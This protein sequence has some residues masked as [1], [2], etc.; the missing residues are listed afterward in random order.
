MKK[1]RA[2]LWMLLV[3][4]LWAL[5]AQKTVVEVGVEGMA[6]SACSYRVEKELGKLDGVNGVHVSLK[7]KKARIVF[8]PGAKPDLEKI[9]KTITDAGF[10]PGKATVRT[11]EIQ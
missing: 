8:A 3:L 9:S 2:V 10:T 5:A 7:E 6:C 1:I 4:P 11:E